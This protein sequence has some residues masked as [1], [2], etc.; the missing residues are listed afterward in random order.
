LQPKAHEVK[1]S[2]LCEG[3]M[4]RGAASRLAC[5]NG[6]GRQR[7]AIPTPEAQRHVT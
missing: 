7:I 5:I 1:R 6:L 4:T 3:D 2:D